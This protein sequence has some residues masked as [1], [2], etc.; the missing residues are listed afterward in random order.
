MRGKLRDC[1]PRFGSSRQ[2]PSHRGEG[3]Y[4]Q[5]DRCRDAD[6]LQS[7]GQWRRPF[8]DAADSEIDE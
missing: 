8:T 1:D 4:Q 3:A 2:N 5:K 7:D 6:D